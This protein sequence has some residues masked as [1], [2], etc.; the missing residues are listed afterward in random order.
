MNPPE[1]HIHKNAKYFSDS[2][3]LIRRVKKKI[4][5]TKNVVKYNEK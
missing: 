4:K 1:S 2:T 3:K 5:E